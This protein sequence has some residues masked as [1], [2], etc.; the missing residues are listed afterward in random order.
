[1]SAQRGRCRRCCAGPI[2]L[3][4][5][6]GHWTRRDRPSSDHAK[7]FLIILVLLNAVVLLGQLWPEGA[8]PFARIVNIVFLLAELGYL[9]RELLG[10]R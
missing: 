6:T 10:K 8:P 3:D 9:L 4:R 1:M 7:T 5:R 2:P